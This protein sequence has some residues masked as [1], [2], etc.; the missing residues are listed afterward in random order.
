MKLAHPI[1]VLDLAERLGAELLG[2]SSLLVSGINEIHHVE[3]GDLTFVDHPKYYLK[4]LESAASIV[5]IDQQTEPPPGKALLV[6]EQPFEV[7]N[8]LVREQR[9]HQPLREPIDPTARIGAGTTIEPG[10]VIGPNVLIGRNSYVQSRAVIQEGCIIGDEVLI[11]SG[12]VI[13]SDAFYFKKTADGYRKWRSGGRVLIEHRVDIGANCTINRG[14][15]SDTI[16]GEGSKLDCLVQIGHDTKVGKHCLFAAQVGVAGNCRIG[17]NVIL[18]GQV[19]IAQNVVIESGA[20]VLA[21]SGVG[22]R[23]KAGKSYFGIPS[24]EARTAYREL[25]ALKNL[26]DFFRKNKDR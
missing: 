14:V 4:A 2:D 3:P 1:P 18:Y 25:V 20:V 17:D 26:P 13:G 8:G 16:I 11:Q 7:Y 9:P 6:V 5:L 15:S 21:K 24:R 10:A 22:D 12:A 23:L 19:G